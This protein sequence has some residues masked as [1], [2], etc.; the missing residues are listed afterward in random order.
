M[1]R[2]TSDYYFRRVR[3]YSFRWSWEIYIL[4]ALMIVLWVNQARG[5]SSS[6]VF[7]LRWTKFKLVDK[8]MQSTYLCYS[9]NRAQKKSILAVFTRSLANSWLNPRWRPR[10]WPCLVTSWASSSATTHKIIPHLVEKIKGFPLKIVFK[11]CNISKTLGRGSITPLVPRWGYSF[12]CTC[13]SEGLTYSKLQ[14]GY[15]M[16]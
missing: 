7:Q 9:T 15:H 16:H 8:I 6:H 1:G 12:A 13:T 3:R 5:L 4:N 10:W 2:P 14:K 11:Y